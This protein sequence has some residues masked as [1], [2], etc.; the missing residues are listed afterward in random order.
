VAAPPALTPAIIDAEIGAHAGRTLLPGTL[1]AWVGEGR[2]T[3]P[4]A[5]GAALP[6][7]AVTDTGTLQEKL[8]ILRGKASMDSELEALQTRF[9]E[10]T[11]A[12][13][14][15]ILRQV[16]NMSV[17]SGDM[18]DYSDGRK[19]GIGGV[20]GYGAA[21]VKGIGGV[22]TGI[23]PVG[24]FNVDHSRTAV[25]KTGLGSNT[26]VIFLGN[27][28]KVT[29]ML[30]AGVRFGAQ[31]GPMG[32]TAQ[33]MGRMG[34]A[35]LFSKGLMIRTNK[36]GVENKDLTPAQTQGMR[37]PEGSWKRMS[38]L[39]VNSV[40]EL[41]AQNGANGTPARPA[42]GGEMWAQMVD[43]V[44]DYRDIS[45][46]WNEG[47]SHQ[48]TGSLGLD[49]IASGK[50]GKGFGASGTAGIGIKHTFMN[51][52]KAKDEAGATQTVQAGSGS[53]TSLG[54][55]ASLGVSHPTLQ[56]DGQPDVGIFARHKV[57]VETELV[58]QAKNG[59][60]RI[61]TEDGKVKPNIS[62][63]HR[64]YAVQDD[65][66]KLVN[67][68]SGEWQARLGQR[69]PDGLL[70]GGDD[71][72]RGFLQQMVNLPPGNNRL[73]IERKCLTQDAADTVNACLDRI[74]ALEQPG[75]PVDEGAA[76]Q[77]KDLHKQIAAHV[78][79]ES[80]WQPF[81][82]FVNE[83][84]QRAKEWS[85]GGDMRATPKTPEDKAAG[86][87]GFAERFMGGGKVTLGGKINTAHGGRDLIMLDAQPARV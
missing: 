54:A 59:F 15:N 84:N 67:K 26:G 39:T 24:E 51:H 57:G 60:V 79:A 22:T 8:Q 2:L 13:R 77:I 18:T 55:A 49:G 9:D 50:L 64:E 11:P 76:T 78:E 86:P 45:F 65:F 42:N 25:L 4:S 40:F 3:T 44:G 37:A 73:F 31:L 83:S 17:V 34:G 7:A 75:A 80:S 23:T 41:A 56:R 72:L 48:V 69:G 70:R 87:Q 32:A 20:F 27:E 10:A 33:V 16:M 66:L 14:Q 35:H 58:I 62:Y 1:H 53:R 61:T 12:D 38:E 29:E 74:K 82:L 5:T 68:E 47:K 6:A 46:G 85:L 63:K 28:T 52:S 19:N 21:S 71:A 30:G 43:K 36:T 81:R